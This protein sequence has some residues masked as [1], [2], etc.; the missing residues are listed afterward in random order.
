MTL[1]CFKTH[2]LVWPLF[3]EH[4]VYIWFEP[5]KAVFKNFTQNWTGQAHTV[6]VW[7]FIVKCKNSTL[8]LFQIFLCLSIYFLYFISVSK[9]IQTK[10]EVNL[11]VRFCSK[12][13]FF[14]LLRN[15]C[16]FLCFDQTK[17]SLLFVTVIALLRAAR[18]LNPTICTILSLFAPIVST[19]LEKRWQNRQ[20]VLPP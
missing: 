18:S 7:L 9:Q 20:T 3:L 1:V 12:I 4:I 15:L 5:V 16:I 2:Q 19:I 10:H 13:F 17:Y 6:D 11:K 14:L 8:N